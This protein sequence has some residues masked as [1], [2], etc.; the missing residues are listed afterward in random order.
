MFDCALLGFYVCSLVVFVAASFD[1]PIQQRFVVGLFDDFHIPFPALLAWNFLRVFGFFLFALCI[2]M[3]LAGIHSCL[4]FCV[5]YFFGFPF[6]F[7]LSFGFSF[8]CFSGFWCMG[9]CQKLLID[10]KI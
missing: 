1:D 4:P 6:F 9:S 10:Q 2:P 3:P 8:W 5:V 7:F